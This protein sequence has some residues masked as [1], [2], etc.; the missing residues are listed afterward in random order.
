MGGTMRINDFGH[1]SGGWNRSHGRPGAR[2][3]TLERQVTGPGPDHGPRDATTDQVV[4]PTRRARTTRSW[5]G[6]PAEVVLLTSF[7]PL[8]TGALLAAGVPQ[9]TGFRVIA[10]WSL[11]Q[12]VLVVLLLEVHLHGAA[13]RRS[14]EGGLATRAP[15]DDAVETESHRERDRLH[16]MRTTMAGI[17]MTHRLLRDPR[18]RLSGAE[19]TRLEQL[20]DKE[21]SRLERLLQDD[22]RAVDESVDVHTAVDAVVDSLRLRGQRIRWEGTRALAVGR[23]DDIAE[24]VHIL[25][26]NAM[27]HAPG[28]EVSMQVETTPT[29]VLLRVSDDGPGVPSALAPELFERGTRRPDS[30]GEGIGL[31]IARRL[32]RE[33][34]GD[35]HLDPSHTQPG[36]AFVVTLRASTEAT[37]CLTHRG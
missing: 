12:C 1:P 5:L 8:L 21:I 16:E 15:A 18:D 33:M 2:D 17:G 25:L 27:R 14:D 6:R 35:L 37:S 9:E 10:L 36:A 34:G 24:I 31:Q 7:A 3:T 23:G 29:E 26:H 20:Y 22:V 11:A 19:R 13:L 4:P 28:S 30:P 32:A